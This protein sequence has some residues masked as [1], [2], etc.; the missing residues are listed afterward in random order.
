MREDHIKF[1]LSKTIQPYPV[2]YYV[3]QVVVIVFYMRLLTWHLRVTIED[4]RADFPCFVV[5]LE[6]IVFLKFRAPVR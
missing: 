5:Y 2:W 6:Q 3:S 1:A 4:I